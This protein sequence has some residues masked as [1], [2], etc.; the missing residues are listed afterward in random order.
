VWTP[1]EFNTLIPID[2]TIAH[3]KRAIANYQS[4]LSQLNYREGF[5]GLSAYRSAF[6]PPANFAEAFFVCSKEEMLAL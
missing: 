1:Q 4:Q 6:C 5:I 3:K 2:H